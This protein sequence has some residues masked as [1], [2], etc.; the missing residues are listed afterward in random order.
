MELGVIFKIKELQMNPDKEYTIDDFIE[1][2]SDRITNPLDLV[3]LLCKEFMSDQEIRL[4]S[5][6]CTRQ[7]LKNIPSPDFILIDACDYAEKY[8]FKLI[9]YSEIIKIKWEVKKYV[10]SLQDTS[11]WSFFWLLDIDTKYMANLTLTMA[12]NKSFTWVD[13]L[14]KL[15]EIFSKK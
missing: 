6:W 3:L 1:K 13:Q 15:K 12:V 9:E 10:M 5:V 4:F 14:K 2:F 7:I 8:A 11:L